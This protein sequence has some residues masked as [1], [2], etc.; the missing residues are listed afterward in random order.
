METIIFFTDWNAIKRNQKDYKLSWVP[1]KETIKELPVNQDKFFLI[2]YD[3]INC[4]EEI[5][6]KI[7]DNSKVYI[8]HHSKPEEVFLTNIETQ[9]KDKGCVVKRTKKQHNHD[10]YWLIQKIDDY[11]VKTDNRFELEKVF[12][13]LK[14]MLSGN[15]K[16]NAALEFLH[17]C[18]IKEIDSSILTSKNQ[19]N[20]EDN[21]SVNGKNK[22][23]KEWIDALDNKKEEEY[24]IALKDVR[25][26]LLAIA[27]P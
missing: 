18:L 13:K 25:D 21:V 2:V 20:L 23:L 11:G 22:K 10:E 14:G 19:F 15:V 4:I 1:M 9:L 17:E 5:M 24:N 8:L 6:T 16:L 27:L 3:D 26:A 7:T 12:D